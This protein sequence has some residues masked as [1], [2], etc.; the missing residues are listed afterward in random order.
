M[1]K[2]SPLFT[3][4]AT[5]IGGRNGHT[6]TSDGAVRA[7]LSVPKELNHREDARRGQ[8]HCTTRA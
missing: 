7:D 8:Q 4:T 2:I 3:A 5:A 6:E 1:D